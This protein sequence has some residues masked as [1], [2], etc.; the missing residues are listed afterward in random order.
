MGDPF[1]TLTAAAVDAAIMPSQSHH[2]NSDT[3]SAP[4]ARLMGDPFFGL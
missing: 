3:A 1:G 4:A 2:V